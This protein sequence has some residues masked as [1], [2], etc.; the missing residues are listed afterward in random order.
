MISC[1]GFDAGK[2]LHNGL[3]L[4]DI[5]RR[6]R[7]KRCSSRYRR[8]ALVAETRRAHAEGLFGGILVPALEPGLPGYHDPHYDPL[9]AVAAELD[10]ICIDGPVQFRPDQLW[11]LLRAVK[12]QSQILEL[13]TDQPALFDL[14]R[15]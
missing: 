14:S 5:A 15:A 1:G 6:S 10:A 8:P 7:D 2:I 13:Y 11:T 3:H 4:F 9:W 12:V